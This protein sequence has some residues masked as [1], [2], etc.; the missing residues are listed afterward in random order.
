MRHERYIFPVGQGGFACEGISGFVVAYDCGSKSAYPMVESCVDH[1]CRSVDHI[2]L[3][4]ISHFDEDHVNGIKYL[5][6]HVRISKAVVS[7]VP[8]E[9]K[10]AFGV[11]TNGAYT[12]IMEMLKNNQVETVEIAGG[13]N[14]SQQ[15]DI[16]KIWEWVA[17]SMMSDRD[18]ANV[19]AYMGHLG[20]DRSKC[21][22]AEY[23]ESQKENI[24]KAFK[25][26]FGRLGPNGKG[27]IVL[28]QPCV[29]TQGC[30]ISVGMWNRIRF[31]QYEVQKESTCLYVG[32]ADLKKNTA[33]V[34]S[35]LSK[36]RTEDP[37]LLMQIP[38]HG[39]S[40]NSSPHLDTEFPARY[41]FV[42][43][44][45]TKRIQKNGVLYKILT[46]RKQLLVA[47]GLGQDLI[48]TE[49]MI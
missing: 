19:L 21:E 30:C 5:L 47:R 24:N 20:I 49:T 46:G 13:E 32:D 15:F 31:T 8:A 6:D 35:F 27:L 38:H 4:F 7:F 26:V 11:Y 17:K 34:Q 37:L 39:S 42:N 25:N 1:L 9:L 41:Y 2:D 29:A 40:A 12:A 16:K 3:L 14:R 45:D 23:L 22:N 36:H 28:S 44:K 48:K 18:F 10:V 43:D 33:E